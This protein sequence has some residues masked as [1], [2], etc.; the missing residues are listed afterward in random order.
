MANFRTH[1]GFGV[2]IGIGF[3][4][5]GLIYALFSSP[6]SMIWIFLAVLIGSFLPDLDMDK[7][8]P[9]QILFGLL[10]AGV[11]G[12]VFLNLYQTGERDFK[13]LILIPVLFFGLVRFGGG[14][15]FEKFTDHRGI[16]HSIPGA[17]L[18]GLLTIWFL[19][20]ISILET[21]K[22][23][24]GIGVSVG[25]LGH[26]VL[27]EIYSSVNLKG[28]SLLPKQSLGN[29][30]KFYSSSKLASLIFYAL[31][32]VLAVNLPETKEIMEMF[33]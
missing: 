22:I 2:F 20:S 8:I 27:D 16:F 31:I 24:L 12:L 5:F 13:N 19:N 15:V 4:V 9:F 14:Y 18:F 25:Y 1:M 3:I 30:L 10:G 17:I 11:A 21:Q 6:E 23:F 28:H 7:G 32:F 26:L 29:A 33:R